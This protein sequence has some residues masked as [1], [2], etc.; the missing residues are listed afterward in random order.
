M[1]LKDTRIAIGGLMTT[2][3]NPRIV[4]GEPICD[5]NCPLCGLRGHSECERTPVGAA[6]PPGLRRQRDEA[7]RELCVLMPETE[8]GRKNEQHTPKAVANSRGW[9]GLFAVLLA[10][11]LASCGA[12]PAGLHLS[13]GECL[14]LAEKRD[15]ALLAGKILAGVGAVTPLAAVPDE[16][17]EN[18]RWGVGAGA[19]TTAAVGVA[20]IWYGERK[21]QMF[22]AYCTEAASELQPSPFTDGGVEQ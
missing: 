10:L 14:D 18:A 17:P 15:G 7:R 9:H 6:C 20:V 3:I 19:A 12:P 16:V 5:R 13:T 1:K 22:T 8:F 21:G 11:S 4:D 2:E